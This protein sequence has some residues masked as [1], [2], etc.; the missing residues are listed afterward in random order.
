MKHRLPVLLASLLVLV[1]LGAA[2]DAQRDQPSAKSQERVVKESRPRTALMRRTSAC[3]TTLPSRWTATISLLGQVGTPFAEVGRGERGK[4]YLKASR[5]S[6]TRLKVLPQAPWTIASAFGCSWS[7][8]QY[9][10]LQKYALGVQKPIRIIVKNGHVTLEGVVDSEADK[11]LAGI[12]ANGVPGNAVTNNLQVVKRLGGARREDARS[13]QAASLIAFPVSQG[14]FESRP[15]LSSFARIMPRMTSPP[16][17]INRRNA[18]MSLHAMNRRTF[19]ETATTAAAAT[20]LTSRLGWAASEHKIEKIGVQLY[21]VR[22]QMKADFDGTI[23]KVAQIGYRKWNSPDIS[24]APASKSAPPA[25]RTASPPSPPT[26]N[27]TNSTTSF[28]RSL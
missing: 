19:L 7:I 27:M 18:I 8:Y 23:A 6:I 17:A 28:P 5:R 14:S 15:K 2:Q 4:T 25:T 16:C 1:T 21:T 13:S 10:S 11:N 24:A 22:D 9:P 3:L 20:L 12:R 26:C